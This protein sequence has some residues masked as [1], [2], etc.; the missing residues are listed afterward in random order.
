[1]TNEE[2]IKYANDELFGKGNL[3]IVGEIFSTNYVVHSGCK[4]YKGHEPIKRFT[5]QL[6]SAIPD[7]RVED[8]SIILISVEDTI[9]W[10]RTLSGTHDANMMGIPPTG[11]KVEWRDMLVT[12]F[13]DE[14]IAEEWT[15]SELV[16]QLLIKSAGAGKEIKI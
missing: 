12:R 1:M 7:I 3:E 11:K 15:V 8:V 6:R 16:G 13:D 4:D 9:A 5:R 2:K 10:Q 14:K